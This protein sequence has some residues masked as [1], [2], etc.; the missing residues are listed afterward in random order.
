[1]DVDEVYLIDSPQWGDSITGL[2][3]EEEINHTSPGMEDTFFTWNQTWWDSSINN[4]L[5]SYLDIYPEEWAN[6]STS[7]LI[8]RPMTVCKETEK[9]PKEY[10]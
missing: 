3:F 4:S 8:G 7:T 2:R 1:M 5:S 10:F 6:P 9:E